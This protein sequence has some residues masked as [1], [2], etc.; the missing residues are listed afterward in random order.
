MVECDSLPRLLKSVGRTMPRDRH[1]DGWVEE[2]GK[3][4]RKWRGHYYTRDEQDQRHHKTVTLGLR[5]K[6]KKWEAE[7]KLREHIER[8]IGD[9]GAASPDPTFAWFWEKRF[10]TTR[11]WKSQATRAAVES[12]F[13]RHV[14]P[15]FGPKRLSEL[16]KFDIQQHITDLTRSWSRS[17]VMKAR[18]YIRAALEEAIEQDILRK[19][20][21][22]KLPKPDTRPTC[23]RYLQVEEIN[24]LLSQMDARDRLISRIC[25]VCGLRPGE[26]FAARWDDFDAVSGRLR[27]D[28][29]ASEWGTK[30]PKTDPSRA[31]VWMPRSLVAE[32]EAWR[33]VSP[34]A[35]LIFPSQTK[36][37]IRT[38]NFLRRHI[39]PA[40]IRAGIMEPRPKKLPKGTRWVDK[41]TSVNFQAFRR[42]CATWFQQVGKPKDIQAH[43]RHATPNTTMGTYV[44]EIPES[45]RAAVEALD[46]KLAMKSPTQQVN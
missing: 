41:S 9:S 33:E 24:V 6:L 4:T 30:A 3:G 40:A 35:G 27:V 26:L 25:I 8:I 14:L 45:V 43:L 23:R 34:D 39:W 18:T 2:V 17:I 12:V 22:R 19:N 1:Q 44:Q 29:S 46:A 31:W 7:A 42:T 10:L 28:E 15:V 36:T 11:E 13:R 16:N 32:L 20:T 37:P 5:S 21:A 38:K